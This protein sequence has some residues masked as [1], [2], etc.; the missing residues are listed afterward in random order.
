MCDIKDYIIDCCAVDNN[1][2]DMF[3]D[4]KYDS[5]LIGYIYSDNSPA[6]NL[7]SLTD[8]IKDYDVV[9]ELI[10]KHPNISFVLKNDSS[11]SDGVDLLSTYNK[12][13]LFMDGFNSIY[14]CLFK[15]NTPIVAVY[16]IDDCIDELIM[17]G[18]EY[19]EAQDYFSYNCLC[20][21]VGENTPAFLFTYN[22]GTY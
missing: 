20:S 1:I 14:G 2:D 3:L 10:E 6:Y 18:M 12:N 17:N 21:Y 19:D 13:M 9:N 15:N 7:N 5:A 11:S 22:E 8:I 16:N 4:E